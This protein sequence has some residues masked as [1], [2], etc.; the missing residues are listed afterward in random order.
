MVARV[1]TLG[2]SAM[3]IHCWWS[4]FDIQR[5]WAKTC[6]SP[7]RKRNGPIKNA[8]PVHTFVNTWMHRRPIRVNKEKMS[9]HWANFLTIR[10]DYGNLIGGSGVALLLVSSHYRSQVDYI[11]RQSD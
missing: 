2:C 5:W 6:C 3:A 8:P 9:S 7:T 11:R 10:E 1:G 4:T